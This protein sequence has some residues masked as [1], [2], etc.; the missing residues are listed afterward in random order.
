[1]TTFTKSYSIRRLEKLKICYKGVD[2]GLKR[3]EFIR[4]YSPYIRNSF[5]VYR[6]KIQSIFRKRYFWIYSILIVVFISY[7]IKKLIK[8]A[9][10]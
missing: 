6:Q 2:S 10:K 4:S 1:M 9:N 8:Y 3:K 7:F 5:Y